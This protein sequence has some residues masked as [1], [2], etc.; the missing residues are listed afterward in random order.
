MNENEDTRVDKIGD[1]LDNKRIALCVTGGIAAIETPKIARMLRRYGADVHAYMSPES[2]KMITPVPLEWATGNR[3]ITEL[4]GDSEHIKTYDAVLIAPATLN[5]I[6]QIANGLA[7]NN[8]TSLVA[9]AF[10]RGTPIYVTPTMHESLEKNP[11]YQNNLEKLCQYE[12]FHVIN[13]RISEGKAKIERASTIAA[14]I[15]HDITDDPIKGKK[16]LITGGSTP[17]MIDDVRMITN[18]FKGGLSRQIAIEAYLRG[19]D[20]T[21]LL[22]NSGIIIPS[23]LHTIKHRTFD[24]YRANVFSELENNYDA[25]IFAAAVAD[26]KPVETFEG[27]IPSG[28]ELKEIK[29]TETEKVIKKVRE[30]FPDL[31]M[32][33]FKYERGKSTKQ[34]LSIAKDRIENKGFQHVVA[35]RGEDMSKTTYLAY[36]VDKNSTHQVNSKI[37]ASQT[38]MDILGKKLN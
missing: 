5:T 22:G 17:V 3:V 6:G 7:E 23:Y 37:E 11:M 26:Y 27:K 9:S 15:S 28:G 20:V 1:Y 33:T 35:N 34:L 18:K 2:Q 14:R 32:V 21:L 29:F 25:G 8:L 36:I 10:G 24:E 30:A 4:T 31:Y 38:L 12:N 19:A 16:L 13:P